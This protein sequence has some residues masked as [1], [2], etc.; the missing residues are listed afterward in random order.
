M[1]SCPHILTGFTVQDIYTVSGANILFGWFPPRT[2]GSAVLTVPNASHAQGT[3]CCKRRKENERHD[4]DCSIMW[5]RHVYTS[6][7]QLFVAGKRRGHGGLHRQRSYADV[8]T[9]GLYPAMENALPQTSRRISPTTS[10]NLNF[11]RAVALGSFTSHSNLI[12]QLAGS[13]V[14]AYIPENSCLAIR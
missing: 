9:V 4:D 11:G 10:L 14:L 1:R 2:R 8:R 5:R 13:R 3:I 12:F 6:G 7:R